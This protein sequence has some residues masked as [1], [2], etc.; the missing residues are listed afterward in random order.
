MRL[1]S[2]V[3]AWRG[4]SDYAVNGLSRAIDAHL[5]GLFVAEVDR[6]LAEQE[7]EMDDK[8][9]REMIHDMVE[10]QTKML[11]VLVDNLS[12]DDLIKHIG[13]DARDVVDLIVLSSGISRIAEALSSGGTEGIVGV[14]ME[15]T[16]KT[17][18]AINITKRFGEAIGMVGDE[19]CHDC[20]DREGCPFADAKHGNGNV[21]P[22]CGHN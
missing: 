9:A 1:D 13:L 16:Q 18:T 12:G 17:M 6:Y 4:T 10:F 14:L 15:E 3:H 22:K 20:K 5:D 2:R 21:A 11:T 7:D 8:E 19:H